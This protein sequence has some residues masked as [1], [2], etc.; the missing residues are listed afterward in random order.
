MSHMEADPLSLQRTAVR[1]YTH[2]TIYTSYIYIFIYTS[3][4]AS[5]NYMPMPYIYIYIIVSYN[6]SRAC[7]QQLTSTH[8]VRVP[9]VWNSYASC[10]HAIVIVVVVTATVTVTV[11]RACRRSLGVCQPH[12]YPPHPP[13]SASPPAPVHPPPRSHVP[14]APRSVPLDGMLRDRDRAIMPAM[15]GVEWWCFGHNTTQQRSGGRWLGE[16]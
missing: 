1:T 8:H 4:Y 7:Q 14:T 13:Q 5:S 3:T 2:S 10:T 12:R 6:P 9:S 11:I 15:K 16:L